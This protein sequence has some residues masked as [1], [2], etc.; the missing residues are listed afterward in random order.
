MPGLVA[1]D[2]AEA[3]QRYMAISK[4]LYD[5]VGYGLSIA[6]ETRMV[7]SAPFSMP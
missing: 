5:V 4:E 6:S 2:A 1:K 7:K 3:L